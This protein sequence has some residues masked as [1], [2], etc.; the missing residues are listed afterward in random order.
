MMSEKRTEGRSLL[1]ILAI[2]GL[3]VPI[4]SFF[5]SRGF[6][7]DQ[8][9]QEFAIQDGKMFVYQ[10]QLESY[11]GEEIKG[12][13]AISVQKK[14]EKEPVFGVIWFTSRALT[15]RDTRMVQFADTHVERIRFPQSTSEQEKQLTEVLMEGSGKWMP[16]QMALDR[17]LALTAAV[18]KGKM[19]ADRLNMDPPK[20]IFTTI[21][22]A[23][24]LINGKPELRKVESSTFERVMNTPFLILFDP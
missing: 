19:Q 12:R 15:D 22:S 3:M 6:A 16:T 2:L 9:P 17:L 13:A 11:K 10:P 7:Q 24:I 1:K 8:W 18:E 4:I 5:S 14:D 23:L 21:P 20:I